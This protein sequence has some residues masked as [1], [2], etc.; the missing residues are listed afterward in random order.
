MDW[1]ADGLEDLIVGDRLGMVNHFHRLPDG[2]LT[3]MPPLSTPQGRID[4]G[5]NSAPRVFDWNSDGLPDLLVGKADPY[6]GSVLL[7]TNSGTP[8]NPVLAD[9]CLLE[10]GGEPISLVYSVPRVFDLDR[11]GRH[12]LVL[13]EASGHVYWFRNVGTSEDPVLEEGVMLECEEGPVYNMAESRVWVGDY[14]ADGVPDLLLGD[15]GGMVH[16]YTGS[17]TT[18]VWG[19][20][21]NP[22]RIVPFNTPCSGVLRL[23]I[24]SQQPGRAALTVFSAAGRTVMTR[25]L[26]LDTGESE[27][28]GGSLPAGVYMAVLRTGD[29]TAAA[30]VVVIP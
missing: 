5:H 4:V 8:G 15:Y 9:S 25:R 1:N 22:L 20:P 6:P 19:P 7:Y 2:T 18:G 23:R 17:D 29:R 26:W 28:A 24:E 21:E 13:G 12:D 30:R 27:V 16:L 14:D 3:E 11:D 10:A